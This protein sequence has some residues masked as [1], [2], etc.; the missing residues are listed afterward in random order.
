MH[1]IEC[2]ANILSYGTLSLDLPSLPTGSGFLN[3][4]LTCRYPCLN[5]VLP[6]LQGIVSPE[7]ACSLLDIFFADPDTAGLDARCP[8]ILTP[9]IRKKSLLREKA[10]R[11]LSPAFLVTIL[12]CVSHTANLETLQDTTTR[13]RVIQSLYS[14]SMKL[15]RARDSDKWHRTTSKTIGFQGLSIN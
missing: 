13:S 2:E 7:D 3:D 1:S 11:L 14:L 9:V 15:L 6:A 10:P 12:W 5:P 8:Y 4:T